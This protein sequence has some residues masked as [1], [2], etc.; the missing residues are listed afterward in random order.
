MFV[1][2]RTCPRVELTTVVPATTLHPVEIQ[3]LSFKKERY[4]RCNDQPLL[5][6]LKV[7]IDSTAT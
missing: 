2:K 5:Q 7:E 6:L 4:Y 1:A 3:V